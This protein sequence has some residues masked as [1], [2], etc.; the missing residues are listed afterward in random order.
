[1]SPDNH[2]RQPC[3]YG[4]IRA[5]EATPTASCA[6]TLYGHI[7]TIE[8]PEERETAAARLARVKA[9]LFSPMLEARGWKGGDAF[10]EIAP[11]PA[12]LFL[13]RYNEHHVLSANVS[14]PD[15]VLFDVLPERRRVFQ[16]REEL[17]VAGDRQELEALLAVL[18]VRFGIADGVSEGT[19]TTELSRRRRSL[20]ALLSRTAPARDM[21]ARRYDQL[22]ALARAS[23]HEQL[24]ALANAHPSHMRDILQ[25]DDRAINITHID[26]ATGSARALISIGGSFRE[27]GARIYASRSPHTTHKEARD[28]AREALLKPE[29]WFALSPLFDYLCSGKRWC[30]RC[31]FDF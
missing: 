11:L 20:T 28:L 27:E 14:H 3:V 13:K 15:G 12:T 8:D 6:N 1:M 2:T 22:L 29:A 23:D 7:E 30:E 31:P 5:L 9:R 4:S 19:I 10:K 18:D 26:D 21:S 24:H 16:V 17:G 25:F